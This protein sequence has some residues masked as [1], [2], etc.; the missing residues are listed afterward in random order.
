M[1]VKVSDNYSSFLWRK[2]IK[3]HIYVFSCI[4]RIWSMVK[5]IMHMW[6][7]YWCH[8]WHHVFYDRTQLFRWKRTNANIGIRIELNIK[9]INSNKVHWFHVVR[10]L[11]ATY[12]IDKIF[13][14]F[15]TAAN[16][17]PMTEIFRQKRVEP[18][19]K[20]SF[21]RVFVRMF[22]KRWATSFKV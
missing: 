2:K 14:E 7:I 13:G 6:T 3:L 11:I 8:F 15:S 17:Q 19:E 21:M 9:R 22:R 10:D 4:L 12:T 16:L 5:Q 20:S 18:I 1:I